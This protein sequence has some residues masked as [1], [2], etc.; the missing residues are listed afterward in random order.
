MGATSARIS[1]AEPRTTHRTAPLPA[2]GTTQ[3]AYTAGCVRAWPTSFGSVG[4]NE[5]M[6]SAIGYSFIDIDN[7]SAQSADAF[8]HGDYAVAN[9]MFYPAENVMLGPELQYGRR[10]NFDDGFESDDFRI[11]FSAKYNFSHQL[12]GD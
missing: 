12:G 6:S 11:Q 8:K 10:E 5:Q 1:S 3:T 4:W 7:S 9:V 2:G